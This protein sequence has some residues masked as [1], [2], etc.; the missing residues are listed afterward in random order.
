MTE[1]LAVIKSYNTHKGI[2]FY[3]TSSSYN[4]SGDSGQLTE[5][6][7]VSFC[8]I[9]IMP[10]KKKP[11]NNKKTFNSKCMACSGDA[12]RPH[13]HRFLFVYRTQIYTEWKFGC[14][15]VQAMK[16]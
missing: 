12:C 3:H 14:H 11:N 10:Q 2:R 9:L 7:T 6:S 4:S 1:Y 8:P 15:A 5:N 13:A 16:N